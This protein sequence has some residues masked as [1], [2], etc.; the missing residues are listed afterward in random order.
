MCRAA[1]VKKEIRAIA[2]TGPATLICRFKIK[3]ALL[4][5]A[6]ILYLPVPGSAG[7]VGYH[8]RIGIK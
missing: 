3:S 1:L 4:S 2:I 6:M 7:L 5:Y 8:D